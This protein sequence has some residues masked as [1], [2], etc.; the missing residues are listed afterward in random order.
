MA[1]AQLRELEERSF[2]DAGI[3][4]IQRELNGQELPDRFLLEGVYLCQEDISQEKEILTGEEVPG[5]EAPPLEET[6]R[7]K[8]A[9]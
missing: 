5:L 9:S 3:E 4:I 1:E 7:G 2:G 6:A 8:E